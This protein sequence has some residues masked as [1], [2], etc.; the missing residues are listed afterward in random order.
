[1]TLFHT[2]CETLHR[3]R[4]G[5]IWRWMRR[6]Q[7]WGGGWL[8]TVS[9]PPNRG[10]RSTRM[11]RRIALSLSVEGKLHFSNISCR[12]LN[13][14]HC[15]L[16]PFVCPPVRPSIHLSVCL[17][18]CLIVSVCLSLPYWLLTKRKKNVEKIKSVWTF[19][20]TGVTGVP[21]FSSEGQ[22]SGDGRILC[23]Y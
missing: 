9:P 21:F 22:R 6:G 20:R 5:R 14:P 7:Q 11:W 4:G 1:M 13:R 8:A 23:R 18:V 16:S 19:P 3:F 12:R 17:S 2:C 10:E 15:G